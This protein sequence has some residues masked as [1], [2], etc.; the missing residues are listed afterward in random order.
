M[1]SLSSTGE[2]LHEGITF[3]AAQLANLNQASFTDPIIG[4][5]Y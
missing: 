5:E 4:T 2:V 1:A 3:S